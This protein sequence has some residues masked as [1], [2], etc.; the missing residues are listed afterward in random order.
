MPVSPKTLRALAKTLGFEPS[1]IFRLKPEELE[2][3]VKESIP[4]I[5]TWGDSEAESY[6]REASSSKQPEKQE[7]P[8][9][10]EEEAT[11]R[12]R[13]TKAQME[14]TRKIEAAEKTEE[15]KKVT[16]L[17]EKQ[18]DTEQQESRENPFRR[19]KKN[20]VPKT[21]S[22]IVDGNIQELIERVVNLE[23]DV[24]TIKK[25]MKEIS[26]FLT[27]FHNVKIDPAEPIS[28]LGEID[29]DGCIDDQLK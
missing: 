16:K 10:P 26:S 27:W 3:M 11:K 1:K 2:T 17:A 13:R 24:E 20:P 5:D 8:K 12:T 19:R 29:W 15:L 4:E 25:T 14:E 6:I 23:Q 21:A 9:P 28:S 22:T 7:E 18:E